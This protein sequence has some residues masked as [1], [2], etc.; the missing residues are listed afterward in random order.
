MAPHFW[1][2]E[3]DWLEGPGGRK[4]WSTT[5]HEPQ[6]A[7]WGRRAPIFSPL[8]KR[9]YLEWELIKLT[10][11]YRPNGPIRPRNS[12]VHWSIR[13]QKIVPTICPFGW[14]PYVSYPKINFFNE[15]RSFWPTNGP[16]SRWIRVVEGRV[17]DSDLNSDLSLRLS[18]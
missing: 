14:T 11:T 6:G 9:Q 4:N 1:R 13:I 15:F 3:R 7:H 10:N 2:S 8:G 5:L 18:L 12:R 17:W 16:I